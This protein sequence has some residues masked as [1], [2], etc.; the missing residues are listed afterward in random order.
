MA[1]R[2]NAMLT[3]EDRRWL[4]GEKTYDGKHAKQQRYQRRKDIRERIYNSILDFTVLL[5][6]LDEDERGKIFEGTSGNGRVWELED[7]QLREGIANG[8]AFLLTSV[9]VTALLR[10][11]DGEQEPT[12]AEQVLFD[13]LYRAGRKNGVLVE[14]MDVR[15]KTKRV[16]IPE[17]LSDL[18]AGNEISSE[19]LRLL[20]ESDIADKT[21][22][23]ECIRE[24]VF[25]RAPLA[26]EHDEEGV[27]HTEGEE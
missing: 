13:A 1:N 26:E 6:H 3:S 10:G 12:V 25:G 2:K 14:D 11:T 23:Q 19:G 9:D 4:T 18:E 27:D 15:L 20:I 17:L 21:V 5:E 22:V 24:V 7:E 8:L 16:S